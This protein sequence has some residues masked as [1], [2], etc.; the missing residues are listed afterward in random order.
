MRIALAALGFVNGDIE[1]NVDVVLR[2][3]E[4]LKNEADF[5]I[6]GETFLQGFDGLIWDYDKDLNIA[7]SLED[8]C[9]RDIQDKAKEM[10]VALSIGFFERYEGKL[11][12]SQIA[13]DK[14]GD[15][16]HVYRRISASWKESFVKDPRYAEG[17]AFSSFRFMDKKFLVALCGD[18]W[19]EDILEK[20]KNVE[21]D[22]LIWPVY[23]D[24]SSERWNDEEK[25]AY[26]DQ[27]A[28]MSRPTFLVNCYCLDKEDI[29]YYSKGGACYFNQGEIVKEIPSG[30][31]D[32]LLLEI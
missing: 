1:H 32:I 23:L 13:I 27:A 3:L 16:I 17:E 14:N 28:L 30:E 4:K 11:Y 18:L 25:F 8:S 22:Y 2:T 26:R 10:G 15:I 9:I 24:Y 6:F 12:D 5:V 29:S 7:F 31:E 21:S 19:Y 20:A